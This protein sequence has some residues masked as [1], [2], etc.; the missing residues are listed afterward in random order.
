MRIALAMANA[1]VTGGAESYT[2]SIIPLLHEAGHQIALICEYDAPRNRA[3]INTVPSSPLWLV[4]ESGSESALQELRRWQPAVIFS[5]CMPSVELEMWLHA[6]APTVNFVHNYYGLCIS[7]SKMFSFPVPL[8]CNRPLGKL[9]FAHFYPHRCGG[10]NPLTMLRDYRHQTA[11]LRILRSSH[12][13]VTASEHVR[14]ELLR[15]GLA[16]DIV[17]TVGLPV[18]DSIT[19]HPVKRNYDLD[20]LDSE[21]DG[22]A[23]LPHRVIF[24]GRMEKPKGASLLIDAAIKASGLLKRRLTLTFAGDG[25]ERAALEGQVRNLGDR[26]PSVDITFAGWLERER[27]C[28]LIDRSDLLAMPSLWPEPFGQVGVEAGL[29]GLPAV[30]FDGGGIAEW[31]EDGVNGRL[32]RSRPPTANAFALALA[33]CLGDPA[34]H[35]RLRRGARSLALRFSPQTHLAKLTTVLHIAS[36]E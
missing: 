29:R 4:N 2:D 24:V 36:R 1:R 18:V 8:I 22:H 20:G 17:H 9:C 10:L 28:A 35:S 3:R 12:A 33:D 34:N 26:D 25:R 19:T 11:R 7:E 16:P 13:I 32:V 31:L 5:Q 14:L 21:D 23:I 30:A 27:L 6:I 15:H